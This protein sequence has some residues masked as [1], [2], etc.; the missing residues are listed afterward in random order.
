MDTMHVRTT[1]EYGSLKINY[2]PG[3]FMSSYA[4]KAFQLLVEFRENLYKHDYY[5]VMFAFDIVFVILTGLL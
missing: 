3:I 5:G 4:S 2:F 1:V